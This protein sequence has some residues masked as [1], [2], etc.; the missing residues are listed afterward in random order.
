MEPIVIIDFKLERSTYS[1]DLD[2]PFAKVLLSEYS[3]W[4]LLPTNEDEDKIKIIF[5][6]DVVCATTN[7]I[8]YYSLHNFQIIGENK[9]RQE[10]IVKK[11]DSVYLMTHLFNQ[12]VAFLSLDLLKETV[13]INYFSDICIQDLF[14]LMKTAYIF[15]SN[16][17]L[18]KPLIMMHASAVEIKKKYAAVFIGISGA[19]KTTVASYCSDNGYLVLSDETILIW[20]ENDIYYV[21]GTP[22]HGSEKVIKGNAAICKIDVIYLLVKDKRD[23][24]SKSSNQYEN[25]CILFNQWLNSAQ[26]N[27]DGFMRGTS[28]ING[29]A[30]D[31][32]IYNLFFTKSKKFIDVINLQK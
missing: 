6:K 14:A 11:N 25:K 31:I 23:F 8:A 9:E 30:K 19:G 29:M 28:F 16:Y 3:E 13:S 21:Q 22:W 5:R 2:D 12:E 10:Q 24:V 4:F 26:Y 27:I 18:D 1:I 15:I 17:L 32:S 7:M 20:E